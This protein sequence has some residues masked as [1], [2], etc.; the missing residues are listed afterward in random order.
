MNEQVPSEP[1]SSR[2]YL[3]V[4][5]PD[6]DRHWIARHKARCKVDANGCWIWTGFIHAKGYGGTSYRNKGE[7][8]HRAMYQAY[9]SV[10]LSPGQFVCHTC[11]VRACCNPGHL[12]LGDASS[13]NTDASRKGRHYEGKKTECERGHP[14]TPENTYMKNGSRACKACARGRQRVKTGWPADLAYS[15][16]AIPQDAPTERRRFGKRKAA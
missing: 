2:A 1:L 12:W 4:K 11:D 9:Y 15:A 16:P 6:Y 5:N 10:K 3:H 13:N 14:F 8:V 7:K